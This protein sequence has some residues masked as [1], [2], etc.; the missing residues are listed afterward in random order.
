MATATQ[1]AAIGTVLSKNMHS[2]NCD[3]TFKV[4]AK[5]CTGKFPGMGGVLDSVSDI[6]MW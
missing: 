3:I 2:F 6:F 4:T 1:M 5:V